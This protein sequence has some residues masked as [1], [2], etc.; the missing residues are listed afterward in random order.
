MNSEA[1]VAQFV[2]TIQQ[3]KGEVE[4][5]EAQLEAEKKTTDKIFWELYQMTGNILLILHHILSENKLKT[6]S[7]HDQVTIKWLQ[8]KSATLIR[9]LRFVLVTKLTAWLKGVKASVIN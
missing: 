8:A 4:R 9:K 1:R 6:Q 2:H 3:F 7:Q 5:D